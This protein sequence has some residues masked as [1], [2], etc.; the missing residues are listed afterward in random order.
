[1]IE[2]V[3]VLG[4]TMVFGTIAIIDL[5]PPG[6]RIEALVHEWELTP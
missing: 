4:L 1:M 3:H 6:H 5:R 2:S